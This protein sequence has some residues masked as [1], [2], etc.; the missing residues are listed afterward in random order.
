MSRL[1]FVPQ[2]PTP[3]RYQEWWLTQFP[4]EFKKY[5]DEV[6]VLGQKFV[7]RKRTAERGNAKLFSPI[8]SSVNFELY[9]IREYMDLKLLED[10]VLLL[11]DLSFPGF[12]SNALYH[13]K[14]ERRFAICHA[15][16]KNAYDYFQPVRK[17]KW[18]TE[19]AHAE[20]FDAIF[21]ATEYHK[22]KLGWSNTVVTALPNPP[23]QGQPVPKDINIVSVARPSLQKINKKFEKAIEREFGKI[24]RTSKL[25]FESIQDYH[26]FLSQCKL[27]VT[28]TKEDTYGYQ[29]I[30]AVLNN[31]IPIA[32][33]KF[34]YPELLP[35]EFL[36][37]NFDE[38]WDAV[39]SAL[40][41][42]LDI[43]VILCQNLINDFYENICRGMKRGFPPYVN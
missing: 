23:Y 33:N 19:C 21:V 38:L 11:A 10:D 29:V 13:K 35:R 42:D 2:F 17:P 28:T 26:D 40:H 32:P 25:V 1:I 20:L 7:E 22:E 8:N 30:D 16:S 27:M 9:Q 18:K 31:V 3:L 14:P 4:K 24:M 43:P 6:I 37:D 39:N 5:F 15:T 41:G 12:F 36:Y 34:S